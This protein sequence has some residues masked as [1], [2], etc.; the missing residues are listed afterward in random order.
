MDELNQIE[1]WYTAST[2]GK[3]RDFVIPTLKQA[4]IDGFWPPKTSRKVRAILNKQ[5]IS[6]KFV[7]NNAREITTIKPRTA[8]TG[9]CAMLDL[10]EGHKSS[11]Q[12]FGAGTRFLL[13]NSAI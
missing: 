6:K 5:S 3:I 9:C 1:K 10:P 12:S 7:K 4:R 8:T 2:L 11:Q 13:W